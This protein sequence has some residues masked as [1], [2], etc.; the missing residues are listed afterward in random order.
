MKGLRRCKPLRKD[1][2][3]GDSSQENK[4]EALHA[5][6]DDADDDEEGVDSDHARLGESAT[7][8]TFSLTDLNHLA[9]KPGLT[10]KEL[11]NCLWNLQGRLEED[12]YDPEHKELNDAF[13]RNIILG[14]NLEVL[15]EV[16]RSLSLGKGMILQLMFAAV[17]VGDEGAVVRLVSLLH[18]RRY[19]KLFDAVEEAL[20]YHLP[21]EAPH[22]G[23][24][25]IVKEIVR[26]KIVQP[27]NEAVTT[28][29]SCKNFIENFRVLRCS[30]HALI[31]IDEVLGPQIW[32]EARCNKAIAADLNQS[33]FAE[34]RAR[35]GVLEYLLRHIA[36]VPTPE[37]CTLILKYVRAPTLY[38]DSPHILSLIDYYI[39]AGHPILEADDDEEKNTLFLIL[40]CTGEWIN[41]TACL[42]FASPLRAPAECA[43]TACLTSHTLLSRLWKSAQ[44]WSSMLSSVKAAGTVKW[45]RMWAC[46]Y[47]T[48]CSTSFS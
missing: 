37:L 14:R 32:H 25:G 15:L 1:D 2:L 30:K 13:V 5:L 47:N 18:R 10:A 9:L 28:T 29:Y 33:F 36:V 21:D 16:D 24:R 4:G 42:S 6:V 35:S 44:R 8:G 34:R 7:G 41:C 23:A 43:R 38:K 19:T 40:V 39:E 26:L 11:A 12:K 22:S 31:A 46:P 20:E 48:T 45:T 27:G 17:R 3:P